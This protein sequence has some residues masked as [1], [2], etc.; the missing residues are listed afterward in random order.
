[1]GEKQDIT[2]RGNFRGRRGIMW[3]TGKASKE[4]MELQWPGLD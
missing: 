4:V 2:G 1:M 3:D